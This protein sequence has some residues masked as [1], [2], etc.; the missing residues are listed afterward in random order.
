MAVLFGTKP[1]VGKGFVVNFEGS[2][3]MP[4]LIQLPQV[5]NST[6]G[7]VWKSTVILTSAGLNQQANVQ[8][9]HTLKEH[10]Y[11]YSFGQRMGAMEI[12]GM[13]LWDSCDANSKSGLWAIMKFYKSWNVGQQL[14]PVTMILGS[15]GSVNVSG[16]FYN[17]STTFT[18]PEKG[19][20][21]F[22]MHF[23]TLP[24]LW[25]NT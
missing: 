12:S 18:D 11:V 20:I 6:F 13:M 3:V 7:D 17:M 25:L 5:E 10:I 22:R 24:D 23:S 1:G 8:Y 9:M 4:A 14:T 2:G 16:F 15:K 19:L 21:G